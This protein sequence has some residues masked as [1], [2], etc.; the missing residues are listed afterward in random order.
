MYRLFTDVRFITRLK[1]EYLTSNLNDIYDQR[2][3][4]ILE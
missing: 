2:I 3:N 4:G 1:E